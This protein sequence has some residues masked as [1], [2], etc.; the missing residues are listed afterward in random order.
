MRLRSVAFIYSIYLNSVLYC[1]TICEVI[2]RTPAYGGANSV[3]LDKPFPYNHIHW[4]FWN[5][6]ENEKH[7]SCRKRS[8]TDQTLAE[9]VASDHS[10]CLL[11][12]NKPG[13]LRRSHI[14]EQSENCFANQRSNEM[15][16]TEIAKSGRK[17]TSISDINTSLI[18]TDK[19]ACSPFLSDIYY[20]NDNQL[21]VL[22]EG[23][24]LSF[25]TYHCFT[26][27]NE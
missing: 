23:L 11:S 9:R 7:V 5:F 19:T 26:I 3:F 1:Y 14:W 13:F 22:F 8:G 27:N 17:Y 24:Y 20:I 21:R 12:L 2:W 16:K 18:L 25:W 6:A 10:L 4:L 15:L